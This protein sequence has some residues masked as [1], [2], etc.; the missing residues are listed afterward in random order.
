MVSAQ[1]VMLAAHC[2]KTDQVDLKAPVIAYIKN[3]YTN[4]E[5]NDASDDLTAIQA[6]R[7]EIVTAQSSAQGAKRDTLAK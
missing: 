7:N 5:A 6:L 1:H 4:A 2:K 3:T